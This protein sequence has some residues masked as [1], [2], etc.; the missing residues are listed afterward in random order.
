HDGGRATARQNLAQ[1]AA[2]G[3]R[4]DLERAPLHR[5][6]VAALE[7]VIADRIEAGRAQRLAGV[8]ADKA[9]AAGH[10]NG[11][12]RAVPSPSAGASKDLKS[13]SMR[14]AMTEVR[15][16]P[17]MSRPAAATWCKNSGLPIRRASWPASA[18]AGSAP[19]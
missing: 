18:P 2:V 11:R 19:R 1:A 14:R 9:R 4:A 7:A 17:A 8:A 10:Q 16:F 6:R 5:L 15:K 12:H 3:E 13:S